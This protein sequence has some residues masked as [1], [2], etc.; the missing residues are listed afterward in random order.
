MYSVCHLISW[1]LAVRLSFL[2]VASVFISALAAHADT[3][4][5]YTSLSAFQA[6][7]QT[8]VTDNFQGS[9]TVDDPSYSFGSF[10]FQVSP[11]DIFID[12]DQAGFHNSVVSSNASYVSADAEQPSVTETISFSPSSAVGFYLG[13]YYGGEN[14]TIS[15]DG[16]TFMYTFPS[17]GK[18]SGDEIFAGFTS[19]GTF[20][21]VT[22]SGDDE[23]IDTVQAFSGTADVPTSVTP[24]PSSFALLGTGVL[25]VAGAVRRR[26]V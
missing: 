23:E 11:G 25:C 20:S 6:A 18:G 10:N 19:T 3:V 17:V 13:D 15:V 21:S 2:A 14:L 1:S 26:F 5:S 24:E 16:S 8:T 7:S 12:Q 22:I 4:T 9:N